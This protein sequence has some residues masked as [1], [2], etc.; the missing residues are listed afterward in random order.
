MQ[1]DQSKRV[2]PIA[3]S[4]AMSVPNAVGVMLRSAAISNANG[5]TG[6]ST[7]SPTAATM[8]RASRCPNACGTPAIAAVAA[9]M[10]IVMLSARVPVKRS[11]TC[12]VS[13]IYRAQQTAEPIAKPIPSSSIS[14]PGLRQ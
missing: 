9:E 8:M 11:P 3:G 5:S 10:G 4:S 7:A 2:S 12:W 1:D 14:P 13:R 6:N